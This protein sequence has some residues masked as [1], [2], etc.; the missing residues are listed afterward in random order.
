MRYIAEKL[1][2]WLSTIITHSR[3]QK[4]LKFSPIPRQDENTLSTDIT[5]VIYP[6]V[7]SVGRRN[8]GIEGNLQYVLKATIV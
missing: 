7:I 4:Q 3:T 8:S 6:L 1:L 5:L 2:N